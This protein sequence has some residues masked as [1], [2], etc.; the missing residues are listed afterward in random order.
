MAVHIAKS[1]DVHEDVEPESRAGVKGAQCFVVLA[2]MP[3]TQLDNLRK[4]VSLESRP[5]DSRYWR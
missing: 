2:A 3:Q 5:R 1:A 4:R